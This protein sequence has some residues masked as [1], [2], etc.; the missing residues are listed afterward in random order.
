MCRVFQEGGERTATGLDTVCERASGL[1]EPNMTSAAGRQ[2]QPLMSSSRSLI[3]K[4]TQIR[5]GLEVGLLASKEKLA[6]GLVR[7]YWCF[8]KKPRQKAKVL[9]V[10]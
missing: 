1:N 3:G 2:P 7:W 9:Q 10:E 4:L 6:Q 8:T 5:P